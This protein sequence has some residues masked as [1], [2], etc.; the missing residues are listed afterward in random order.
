MPIYFQT[1]HFH[2]IHSSYL[3]HCLDTIGP[4]HRQHIRHITFRID[5]YS[6]RQVCEWLARCPALQQLSLIIRDSPD[7]PIQ[8]ELVMKCFG[9]VRSLL[10][11]DCTYIRYVADPHHWTSEKVFLPG[12]ETLKQPYNPAEITEREDRGISRVNR[13]R[14]NF[15]RE[16]P[17]GSTVRPKKKYRTRRKYQKRLRRK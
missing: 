10:N 8:P 4:Y 1:K 9:K 7:Y 15:D 5:L 2:F 11:V 14:T 12:L 13:V 6:L 3:I 17:Q 16:P